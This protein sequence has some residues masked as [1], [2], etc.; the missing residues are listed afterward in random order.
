MLSIPRSVA[1]LVRAT[2]RKMGDTNATRSKLVAFCA[3]HT[4]DIRAA[5]LTA[6]GVTAGPACPPNWSVVR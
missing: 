4:G 2:F 3:D 1:R 6:E 5:P